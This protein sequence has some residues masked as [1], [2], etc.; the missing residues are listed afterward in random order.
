MSSS[1]SHAEQD[2][3]MAAAQRILCADGLSVSV[4]KYLVSGSGTRP[5]CFAI[6]AGTRR[7]SQGQSKRRR[8]EGTSTFFSAPCSS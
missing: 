1:V 2:L 5:A 4:I 3:A 8:K 6:A 7:V